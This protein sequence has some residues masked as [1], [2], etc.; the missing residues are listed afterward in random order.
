LNLL[1]R[2]Q[3]VYHLATPPVLFGFSSFSGSS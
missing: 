3:V 1:D 2:C